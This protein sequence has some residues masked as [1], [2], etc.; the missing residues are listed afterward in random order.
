M[1]IYWEQT[2]E[3]PYEGSP[4]VRDDRA[5][6]HNAVVE[7]VGLRFQGSGLEN[8]LCVA[9]HDTQGTESPVVYRASDKVANAL[10]VLPD[11][12]DVVLAV[13]K[14]LPRAKAEALVRAAQLC[15]VR[16][17]VRAVRA[18]LETREEFIEGI[19]VLYDALTAIELERAAA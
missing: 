15:G 4:V 5:P 13:N 3:L 10:D 8:V 11:R 19:N 18:M 6:Y 7:V 17:P 9:K 14:L 2:F 12:K 1:R 16:D